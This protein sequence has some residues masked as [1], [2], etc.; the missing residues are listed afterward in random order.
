MTNLFSGNHLCRK[1]I[2]NATTD[3]YYNSLTLCAG[4]DVIILVKDKAAAADLVILDAATLAIIQ[5]VELSTARVYGVECSED[6]QILHTAQGETNEI[7]EEYGFLV[8][9]QVT[10]FLMTS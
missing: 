10:N 5:T 3:L 7:G 4:L 8:A 9:Y 2:D 1:V 6:G